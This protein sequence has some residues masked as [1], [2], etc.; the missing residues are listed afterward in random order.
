M[1]E[2]ATGHHHERWLYEVRV[3]GNLES[4]WTAWFD[5]MTLTNASDGTTVIRGPVADQAALHGLLRTLRDVGLPLISVMQVQSAQPE[6]PPPTLD[7]P[8]PPQETDMTTAVPTTATKRAPMDSLRRTA[9]VAGVFY[10]VTFAASIPAVL[11]INPV[12]SSADYLVASGA[13]TRLLWGGFLDLITALAGIGTAVALFPVVKRQNEAVALGFV[14]SR[15][16]EGAVIVIGVISLISVVT[17][18]QDLAGA[19][20]TEAASLATTG[21]ALVA[22]RDWA[23]LVGPGFMAA[24][25]ALLLG[26]LMYRSGLVPRVIPMMG[27]VGAPLLLASVIATFFGHNEQFSTLSGIAVAP[28]FLWELSVGVYMAVKGFKPSPIASTSVPLTG[29]HEPTLPAT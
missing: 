17:L 20:G 11:L 29:A 10:L 23:L 28:I 4:R 2:A 27:L 3:K 25:N 6:T 8:Q 18:R 15:M 9:L 24:I 26:S 7:N 21:H 16:F 12:L 19:A 1:S 5:G 22:I 14:T 13:D